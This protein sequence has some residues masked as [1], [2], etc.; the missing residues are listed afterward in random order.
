MGEGK[1][2]MRG[3]SPSV[4]ERT[5]RREM[6]YYKLTDTGKKKVFE[7]NPNISI[8][9]ITISFNGLNIPNKID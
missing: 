1:T 5:K 4:Q 6:D 7:I 9:T 8:S 3:D 2:G